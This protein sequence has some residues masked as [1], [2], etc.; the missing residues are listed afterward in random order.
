MIPLK[1][2]KAEML[3]LW[4]QRHYLE[5]LRADC[6]VSRSDS[7]E[8]DSRC[9]QDMRAWYLELLHHGPKRWLVTENVGTQ[10]RMMV[11][12][13]GVAE[14]ELPSNV[15]RVVWV[16]MPGWRQE[17]EVITDANSV[18]ARL[19]GNPFSRGGIDNPVAVCLPGSGV[20]RV[21]SPLLRDGTPIDHIE[22][23]CDSGPVSYI[24][25]PAVIP[26]LGEPVDNCLLNEV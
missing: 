16:R 6:V 9:M 26:H 22:A 3:A 25:H 5:P 23:V 15:V 14:I 13:D 24:L 11:S 20:L 1:Y 2:S 10:C 12:P 7:Y 19:Q 8:V 18:E 21:Y 4:K 17:C